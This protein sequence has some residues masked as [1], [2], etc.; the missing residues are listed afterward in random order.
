MPTNKELE[1]EIRALKAQIE[2]LLPL[3]QHEESFEQDLGKDDPEQ[4]PADLGDCEKPFPSR[5]PTILEMVLLAL[6]LFLVG[7]LTGR[8]FGKGETR[9]IPIPIT[10][11]VPIAVPV[12]TPTPIPHPTPIPPPPPQQGITEWTRD[13][14]G[15]SV[16][17]T[18]T[19]D[20]EKKKIELK[21]SS[22]A[23]RI[24]SGEIKTPSASR[25]IVRA[26]LVLTPSSL[27]HWSKFFDNLEIRL[28]TMSISTMKELAT[29]FDNIAKGLE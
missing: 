3:T 29:V 8:E 28:I 25:S 7:G 9:T 20:A 12:P 10:I 27:T 4:S 15:R 2:T 11:A 6:F 21:M 23:A 17:K 22:I 5:R 13:E 1:Q 18:A 24:R 14:I 16:T 26:E 19:F